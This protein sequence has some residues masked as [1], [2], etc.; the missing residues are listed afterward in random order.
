MKDK[1]KWCLEQKQGIKLVEPNDNLSEAYLKDSK[2]S[3]ESMVSSKGLWKTVMS[4]YAC[5]YALYS[6]LMK[7][8]IKCEIH[9][10]TIALMELLG[11]D[12]NDI[13][14]IEKM[15]KERIGVQYYRKTPDEINLIQIKE[16]VIKCQEISSKLDYDFITKVR[17]LVKND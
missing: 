4:Y 10:C 17:G 12:S 5:Y 3:L 15:K 7:L 13:E 9:S 14:F 11:F 6:L 16:F 2:D 1:I 8:G